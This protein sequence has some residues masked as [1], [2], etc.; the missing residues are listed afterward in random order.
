M[1]HLAISFMENRLADVFGETPQFEAHGTPED[2]GSARRLAGA[3]HYEFQ[4]W[5]NSLVNAQP[6]DG[7]E[8]KGGDLGIDSVIRFID[9]EETL[10][11]VLVQGKSGHVQRNTMGKL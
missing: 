11:R 7:T 5:A 6:F 9:E 4:Y 2:G 1:T 10:K 8:K 3:D